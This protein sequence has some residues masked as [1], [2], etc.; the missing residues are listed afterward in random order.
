M[1]T[2]TVNDKNVSESNPKKTLESTGSCAAME[3]PSD[4]VSSQPPVKVSKDAEVVDGSPAASNEPVTDVQKKMKRAER[5]GMPVKLSEEE[6]RNSRAERFGSAANSNETRAV[7]KPEDQK[8]KARA[9]RFGLSTETVVDEEA[10]KKARLARF[11]A[12]SKVD[13]VE[14]D[15]RKARAMRFSQTSTRVVSNVNGEGKLEPNAVV[16]GNAGG[17]A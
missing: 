3:N 17:A 1:A 15:K 10:K 6:K 2:Q 7:K 9:E 14:H 16:A 11:A 13:N 8:R 12:A 5:F 4:E